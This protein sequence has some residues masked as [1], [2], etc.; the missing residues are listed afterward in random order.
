MKTTLDRV[1]RRWRW[2][3]VACLAVGPLAAASAAVHAQGAGGVVVGRVTDARTQLPIA[4][5]AV[6]VEGTRLGGFTNTDGR[7]RIANV[8]AG[9]QTV[10]AR[11]IGYAPATQTVSVSGAQATADFVL[12]VQAVALD[13]LVVSATGSAE[14]LRAIGNSV[15]KINAVEAVDL[16]APA[17]FQD[18][19]NAR[20]P[21]VTI[22]FNT[23]RIGAGPTIN[24]RGRSSIGQ[25]NSPLIYVDG[26]R[27]NTESGV[28]PSFGGFSGQGAGVGSRLNDINPEDI[29]SIE[30]IKGPA[31]STIYGTEASNGVIQIITKK[32]R[33]GSQS[34]AL[35]L[36][37]GTMWFRDAEGR[38]PTNYFRDVA[39]GQIV[40]W[41]GVQQEKERGTPLFENGRA[42]SITASLSGGA[43]EVRY[44]VS[45]SFQDDTGVEPNNSL[46]QF[47][48]HAN[49]NVTPSP[50]V[51]FSTSLNY[52]D[53]RGHL[54]TDIGASA[55]FG[56]IGGHPKLW[57]NSRGFAFNFPP[58]VTWELWDNQQF[59]RRFTGSGV[60][61]H[62]P[63]S[64]LSQRLLA[65]IDYTAQDLRGLERYAP[66]ALAVYLSP[67]AALGRIGQQL[68]NGARFTL[69]YAGNARA[70]LLESLTATTT[71]GTQVFRNQID[72]SFLGGLGFPGAGVYTVSAAASQLTATQSITVNTTVGGYVQEKLAWRDRLFVTGALRVDNNSAFGEDYKWVSYPKFDAS[73]VVSEEPFFAPLKD[74]LKLNTFRLRGA[75]G[76]SGQAPNAFA[77]LQT[78]SPV[79]GPNGANAVTPGNLGNP[80]LRPE[81]G[82]EFEAGFEAGLFDRF[83][84]DFTYFS[85]KT[86]DQIVNQ[87]VAPSSGFPG[88]IP[89]NLARVDTR[90]LEL[91]TTLNAIRRPDLVWDVTAT[92]ATVKDEIK[93]VGQPEGTI[94]AVGTLNR[95]GYPIGGW[96]TKR[97]VS[98][99]RNP[100]TNLATNVMCDNGEGA[101]VACASAPFLF[102]GT[103]TPT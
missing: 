7:Y 89:L 35:Q 81:R 20:A 19:L 62:Q 37:Q 60:V 95:E 45:S 15:T 13:E 77:A 30:V 26:V 99:D 103:T 55:L 12:P 69:D 9:A 3:A 61:N 23:G 32:G 83:S 72:Q 73:W 36:Q 53:V 102:M 86:E 79:Q 41:N 8:P 29:E 56:A 100:T 93:D 17:T 27:M 71:V 67:T 39:T 14:R 24:I 34:F 57:P 68:R 42:Q 88:S 16:A 65:G 92:L 33:S 5:A 22:N 44:F 4:G 28:G 76:E 94:A 50:K 46:K 85:K 18:L 21:G 90:G 58:E 87:A 74:V 2:L 38:V 97:V 31:A 40:T 10:T 6:T 51:D 84:V 75:Y 64:W 78:F 66:P 91:A 43:D 96:F 82:K 54:G 63:T 11:S 1:A 80:D 101:P 49:L 70:Q 48:L 59:V 25:G 52:V 47:S 98:A